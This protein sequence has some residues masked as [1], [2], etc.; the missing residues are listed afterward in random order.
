MQGKKMG[1]ICI[2]R[3]FQDIFSQSFFKRIKRVKQLHAF[4]H[5]LP[6][7]QKEMQYL[8]EKGVSFAKQYPKIARRLDLHRLGS[9]DPQVQLLL[10]SFAFLT[11][12]LQY[13]IDDSSSWLA[14]SLLEALHP[15]FVN[16]IPS[17][18]I[19]S[20]SLQSETAKQKTS[21]LLPKQTSLF[22][23]S[24][25]GVVCRF[26][27]TMPLELWPLKVAEVS[28]GQSQFFDLPSSL[29]RSPWLLKIRV[30]PL[31][32]SL[33]EYPVKKLQFYIGEN[34]LTCYKLF[35]WIFAY[36]AALDTP[37]F[38]QFPEKKPFQLPKNSL[39]SVGF[40]EDENLIAASRTHPAYRLL[41]EYFTFAKKFLF[42]DVG[43]LPPLHGP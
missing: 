9:D 16:P 24:E 40:Q 28:W 8:T 26:Q 35:E 18:T 32:G 23:T 6:Y 3:V 5:L 12:Q 2:L 10:E 37:I 15:H 7:Y 27:T 20:F 22:M 38:L 30:C 43:S 42:F 14:T 13:K 11:A 34:P 21:F 1:V 17:S 25:E 4:E 41:L 36:D 19:A 29:L 33:E 39:G 31:V